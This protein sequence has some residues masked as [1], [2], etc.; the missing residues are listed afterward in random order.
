MANHTAIYFGFNTLTRSCTSLFDFFSQIAADLVHFFEQGLDESF[1]PLG[2]AFIAGVAYDAAVV[3]DVKTRP[4]DNAPRL[5]DRSGAV[6]RRRPTKI[7][8]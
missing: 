5:G 4:I 3:E 7:A 1:H 8:K 6:L 2:Q